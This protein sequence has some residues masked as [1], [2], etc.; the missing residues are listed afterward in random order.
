[1]VH[2]YDSIVLQSKIFISKGCKSFAYVRSGKSYHY[3]INSFQDISKSNK[4]LNL[5]KRRE[6]ALSNFSF[7]TCTLPWHTVTFYNYGNQKYTFEK[8][9]PITLFVKFDQYWPSSYIASEENRMPPQNVSYRRFK[10]HTQTQA[11]TFHKLTYICQ[12]ENQDS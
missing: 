2:I 12:A 8:H 10:T 9:L 1:M 7:L 11:A 6:N 5:R 3:A 4:L